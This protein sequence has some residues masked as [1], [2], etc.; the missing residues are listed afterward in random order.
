MAQTLVAATPITP[1]SQETG[2]SAST[3]SA[4][5]GTGAKPSVPALSGVELGSKSST[6]KKGMA[7]KLTLSQPATIEVLIAQVLKGHKLGGMCKVTAKRGKS[8]TTTVEKRTLAFSG[9]AGSNTFE[10]RTAG[11]GKGSYIATILAENAN[12]KS[13][14]IRM[15]FTIT[16]K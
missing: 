1:L 4:G 11:L 7:L 14:S 6:G 3:S 9:S 15:A 8:C 5:A 13:S 10:L 2:S 16:V 12:G